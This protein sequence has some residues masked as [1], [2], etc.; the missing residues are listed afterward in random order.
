MASFKE[1]FAKARK[2]LGAGKTFTWSGKSYTTDYAEEAGKKA[3]PKP[4]ARP[5]GLKAKTDGGARPTVGEAGSMPTAKAKGGRGEGATEM[6][7]RSKD[8][9]ASASAA[10]GAGTS[11]S[12]RVPMDRMA[13]AK[14][15]AEERRKKSQDANK[16][17]SEKK[18]VVAVPS[19]RKNPF[20][21]LG[22]IVRGGGFSM[23]DQRRKEA[24]KEKNKKR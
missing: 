2:E 19:K 1:A 10:A 22:D 23:R 24:E 18:K 12:A 8:R 3:A 5:E 6:A 15:D 9:M 20:E 4:K 16:P 21:V 7:R 11:A 13:K 14:M 17:K